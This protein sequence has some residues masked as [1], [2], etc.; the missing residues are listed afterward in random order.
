V[1]KNDTFLSRALSCKG[2][3]AELALGLMTNQL[4]TWAGDYILYPIVIYKLGIFKG[5]TVMLLISFVVCILLLK[6]YDILKRD[7][8]GIE[9]IKSL[10]DYD[11]VRQTGRFTAWLLNKS[12]PI[13][14][15]FLSLKFDPFITTVYLRRGQ[16]NGMNRRD[17]MIFV[18]SLIFGNAYWTLACFMGI[19]LFEWGWKAICG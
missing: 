18:G 12:D 8:L 4:L 5:G 1:N 17:W 16:Y 14:L 10:K 3:V 13:A 2:R 15:L 9:A 6:L 7:W 19:S 11:G